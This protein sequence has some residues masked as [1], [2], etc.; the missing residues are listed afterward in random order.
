[1]NQPNQDQVFVNITTTDHGASSTTQEGPFNDV[2][3]ASN[4]IERTVETY[5]EHLDS[6][7]QEWLEDHDAAPSDAVARSEWSVEDQRMDVYGSDG[8]LAGS[9]SI[10]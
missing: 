3:A 9:Y 7:H 6:R 2:D 8:K 10:G 1:M 5:I 4:W